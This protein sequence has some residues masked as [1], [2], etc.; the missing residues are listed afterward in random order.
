LLPDPRKDRPQRRRVALKPITFKGLTEYLAMQKG[1][2][3]VLDTWGTFCIPCKEEFHNLVEIHR[4]HA[5]QVVCVSLAV[6][7][8]ESKPALAFLQS[9]K[10]TF[11][12]FILN[13]DESIT[14]HEKWNFS[15]VPA[16]FVYDQNGKQH[17]FTM[18]D[19]D[20]QFTYKQVKDLVAKLTAKK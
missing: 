12:N 11:T 9:Q 3:V 7:P 14:L 19:P 2:V 1:K 8:S 5:G 4:Q 6:D 15:A 20:N 17:A 13:E 16:V 10:A 18:D